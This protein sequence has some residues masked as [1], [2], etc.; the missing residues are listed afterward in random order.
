MPVCFFIGEVLQR[1]QG[2]WIHAWIFRGARLQSVLHSGD[3]DRARGMRSLD[4]EEWEPSVC[5]HLEYKCFTSGFRFDIREKV[6]GH[7]YLRTVPP[8]FRSGSH[9]T[10]KGSSPRRRASCILPDQ[11]IIRRTNRSQSSLRESKRTRSKL[12][13]EFEA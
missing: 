4:P 6:G 1:S 12:F 9:V 3:S 7:R 2:A 8:R 11:G 5:S 10:R 13:I